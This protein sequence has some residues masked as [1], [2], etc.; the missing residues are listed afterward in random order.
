MKTVLKSSLIVFV[1][2]I[3]L[4]GIIYF[5]VSPTVRF[6]DNYKIFYV[7][8]NLDISTILSNLSV[9][10]NF[11]N[12]GEI[13]FREAQSYPANN[14]LTPIMKDFSIKKLSAIEM[15]NMFFFDKDNKYQLFYVEES[16]SDFVE[17]ELS[18]KKIDFGTDGK[19]HNNLLSPFVCLALLITLS[20]FAKSKTKFFIAKLPFVLLVYSVSYYSVAIS[21]SC[22]LGLLFVLD[23]YI[24]KKDWIKAILKKPFICVAF[25]VVI[26]MMI[27]CGFRVFC[28][29]LLACLASFSILFL[30][31]LLNRKYIYGYSMKWILPSKYIKLKSIDFKFFATTFAVV[32]FFFVFFCFTTSFR[33]NISE[34]N[35]YLPA[36]SEYTEK[37]TFEGLED[38][39]I[40]VKSFEN[41]NSET[42]FLP[43]IF[44]FIDEKWYFLTFPY[45]KI[46]GSDDSTLNVG[47]V[48]TIPEYKKT[49]QGFVVQTEKSLFSFDE[50][51]ISNAINDFDNS[52]GVEKLLSSQESFTNIVYSSTGKIEKTLLMWIVVFSG[53]VLSGFFTLLCLI[54]RR[55]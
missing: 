50:K 2:L 54:K 21:V 17:K 12:D 32:L 29:F 42:E 33:T 31:Y 46:D 34:N 40:Y 10:G 18:R 19:V 28:L 53:L 23:L 6:W 14:L 24:V 25:F 26:F 16:I 45:K 55:F 37:N 48:I 36:P 27:L 9:Y 20:I 7:D 49:S 8:K 13:I 4:L 30:F 35:L 39:Y 47:K 41:S 1:I 11:K 3:S 38:N 15:R 51:F 43:N 52:L 44:D 22:F 5:R